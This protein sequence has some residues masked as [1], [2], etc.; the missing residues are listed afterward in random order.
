MIDKAEYLDFNKAL[1]AVFGNDA[2]MKRRWL[3]SLDTALDVVPRSILY[4]VGGA[5]LL[6][7]YLNLIASKK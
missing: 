1:T 4:E 6:T 3:D 5:N 7:R 2:D